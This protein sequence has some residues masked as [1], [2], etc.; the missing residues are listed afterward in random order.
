MKSPKIKFEGRGTQLSDHQQQCWIQDQQ[1]CW[2]L[3]LVEFSCFYFSMPK[4]GLMFYI[5]RMG[6]DFYIKNIVAFTV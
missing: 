3:T 2:I 1:Q 6:E 4:L 5:Q